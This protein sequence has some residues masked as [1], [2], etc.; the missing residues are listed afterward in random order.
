MSEFE[1]SLQA[2]RSSWHSR[3]L[4]CSRGCGTPSIAVGGIGSTAFGLSTDSCSYSR[5]SRA[6]SGAR[7]RTGQD[8]FFFVMAL[9]PPAVVFLQANALVTPQPGAIKDWK[10]HFWSIKKW[11]FASNMLLGPRGLRVVHLRRG[12]R[13]GTN[14]AV[15]TASSRACFCRPSATGA[16]TRGFTVYSRS[17]VYSTS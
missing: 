11:F 1:S 16:L 17:S 6:H 13:I 9:T 8:L 10:D 4:D 7:D 3:L 12:G 14:P 2:S 5:P 15:R